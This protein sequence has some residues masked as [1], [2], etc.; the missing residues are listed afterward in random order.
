MNFLFLKGTIRMRLNE[1]L[2]FP[3]FKN[4]TLVTPT[5]LGL[6]N[7]VDSVMVLE[8]ID[9]D[10]WRREN[11]LL[12]TSYFAFINLNQE[13]IETFFEQLAA[14]SIAGLVIKIDRL[15]DEIPEAIIQLCMKHQ[16]PLIKIPE[17]VR[18]KDIMLAINE[19]LLNKQNHVLKSYY[20]ASSIYNNLPI[21]ETT[22]ESIMTQLSQLVNKPVEFIMPGKNVDIF[23][24]DSEVRKGF[25][26]IKEEKLNSQFTH[27]L[28]TITTWYN[29]QINKY[30]YSI[31]SNVQNQLVSDFSLRLYYSSINR[32][33][34][35]ADLMVVENTVH[36]IRQKLQINQ[37]LKQEK[38]MFKN[39]LTSSILQST[40]RSSREYTAL[41][42]EANISSHSHYKL[43]GFINEQGNART[44]INQKLNYLRALGIPNI[45]YEHNEYF[46]IVFNIEQNDKRLM[47]DFLDTNLPPTIDN[48][49]VLSKEGTSH[50]INSLFVECLDLLNYKR[51]FAIDGI[52]VHEDLG[53]FRY[54]A[55][56]DTAQMKDI[57][58]T[59]LQ[60]LYENDRDLFNTLVELFNNNMNYTTTAEVLYIHPKTVRYRIDKLEELLNVDF[61]NS[62][63]FTN[64]FIYVSILQLTER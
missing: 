36:L 21:A 45:Y 49:F 30:Y 64:Y 50:E 11:E 17:S 4:A 25:S 6:D 9:I 42:D 20:E 8:G 38:F 48:N 7:Q 16:I 63:Q 26:Q 33:E 12:L 61:K 39:N 28:Y 51:K 47:K 60:E 43:I 46:I 57:V 19:P 5:N 13:E 27:N 14:A 34:C 52:L 37:L 3:V 15:I 44:S 22:F 24:G 23:V 40:T 59:K 55:N 10:Y 41:L 58:P 18:Y 53:I 31:N 35:E 2:E 54:L 56:M 29:E 32:S 1:I 62:I